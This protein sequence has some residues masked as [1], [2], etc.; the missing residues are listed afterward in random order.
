[1][2]TQSDASGSRTSCHQ[3]SSYSYTPILGEMSLQCGT[4]L[5]GIIVGELFHRVSLLIEEFR[6]RVPRHKKNTKKL[7]KSVL[8]NKH[9]QYVKVPLLVISSLLLQYYGQANFCFSELV[10]RICPVVVW[11][12]LRMFGAFENSLEDL[13]ILE[14][15]N[16][17]LGPGLAAN[18]WFSFL[19][20]ALKADIR[21]KMDENLL[22]LRSL[23][24]E[25]ETDGEW[26]PQIGA[27][28]R[29]F[30]KLMIPLP[31]DCHL[32]IRDERI[33][34]EEN[35]FKCT[36]LCDGTKDSCQHNLEFRLEVGERRVSIKQTVYWIYESQEFEREAD[37]PEKKDKK[38][39][40]NKIF[41]I[42]DLPQLLQSAMGPDRGWEEKNRPGA[43]EKNVRSFRKT[44]KSLLQCNEYIQY[45]KDVLF[46]TFPNK[47]RKEAA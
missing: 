35:I 22:S 11:A 14:E 46:L 44:L 9:S 8:S 36:E 5:L 45:E 29:N 10:I 24:N 17:E 47:E 15:R 34:K 40:A 38:K 27:N 12:I 39:N 28:Y 19:K 37:T 3:M 30:S 18:Y 6:H 32:K 1:M 31:D 26:K 23:N 41:I 33:L 2:G 16:A 43:R 42:F 4:Y 20:P 13:E 21:T 25:M 7:I